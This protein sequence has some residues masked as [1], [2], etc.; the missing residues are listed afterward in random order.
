MLHRDVEIKY[1]S[2]NPSNFNTISYERSKVKQANVTQF[3][4]AE[5]VKVLRLTSK[6]KEV[7][8][9]SFTDYISSIHCVGYPS[10]VLRILKKN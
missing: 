3:T 9:G 8:R 10:I 6:K 4:S 7:I 1:T 5:S 2:S